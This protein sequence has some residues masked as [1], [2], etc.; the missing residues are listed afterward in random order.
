M[1]RSYQQ[2]KN[3]SIFA[4]I[5]SLLGAHAA[6]G[7]MPPHESLTFGVFGKVHLYQTT[8]H[9]SQVVIFI[10][11]DHGWNRK[12]VDMAEKLSEQHALVIG[13]DI[14]MLFKN[15]LQRHRKCWYPGG[16]FQELANYVQRKKRFSEYH[17]PILAGYSSGAALVYVLLAQAPVNTFAG[18]IS[19]DFNPVLDFRG[20]F[21]KGARLRSKREKNKKGF[22][23]MPASHLGV[24]WIVLQSSN[25]NI[26]NP[27]SAKKFVKRVKDARFV[28][29]K[30]A[31]HGFSIPK[32]WT[33]QFINAYKEISARKPV[34]PKL[35]K[36]R[37]K[38]LPLTEVPSAGAQKNILCVLITGDG[39]WMRIDKSLSNTFAENGIAT[40]GLNSLKYLW[41]RKA[42][43]QA[44]IDLQRITQYYRLKWKKKR[45]IYVGYSLGADI[46]PFMLEDMPHPLSYKIL[47][48][49]FLSPSK[50]VDFK[51]HFSYWFGDGHGKNYLKVLPALQG[52]KHF[53]LL[54]VYG[55][56]E[57]NSVCPRVNMANASV[58][59]MTGGHHYDK[60]YKALAVQ[61]LKQIPRKK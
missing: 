39:G 5:F 29:L 21:C 58:M 17:I 20:L 9:P 4:I 10:S 25:D 53:P 42:P 15:M 27:A 14:N 49:V 33:P 8:S 50:T 54:C 23:F 48:A 36:W 1:E 34:G 51:F 44:A 61:I 18:G 55:K 12:A 37:L 38:G 31:E 32:N 28:I 13:V 6:A 7:Q 59:P 35:G 45:V 2:M 43:Q 60:D 46:L 3:L 11:G 24:P 52:L 22:R 57:A 30:G 47:L 26:S 41:K 40:V 56:D 16:D 19:L